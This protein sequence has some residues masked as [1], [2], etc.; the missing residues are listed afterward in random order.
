ME[1]L[2]DLGDDYAMNCLLV[3]FIGYLVLI[4]VE[5]NLENPWLTTLF[6]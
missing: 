2:I 1:V 4:A 3:F 6:G 5:S